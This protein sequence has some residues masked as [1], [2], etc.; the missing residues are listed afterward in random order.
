LK[1]SEFNRRIV[2]KTINP[3][4]DWSAGPP[5]KRLKQTALTWKVKDKATSQLARS[6]ARP[7]V[8]GVNQGAQGLSSPKF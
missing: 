5:V 8:S 3:H 7:A 6:G 2:L 1:P 4:E